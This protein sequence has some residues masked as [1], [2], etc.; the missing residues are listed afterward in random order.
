VNTT[1]TITLPGA[2]IG[3]RADGRPIYLAAGG[4]PDGDE[5]GAGG[6]AGTGGAAGQSGAGDANGGSGTD[7]KGQG[8]S[9]QHSDDKGGDPAATI[10]R[11][12]KDL[13]SARAEAGK[14][15]TTAKQQ[16]ADEAVK[17]VTDQIATA[18]GLKKDDKPDP[19]K[20]AEQ[21]TAAQRDA[22]ESKVELAVFRNASKHQG[23]ASALLDSRSFL[24]TLA[25]LDPAAK[26][27]DSKVADAIKTA[28]DDNPKLKTTGQA[29]GS[30]SV[31][32]AGGTGEKRDRT[33][34]PLTDAVAGHYGTA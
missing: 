5:T 34:R 23:D 7:D 29:P 26:D 15:R 17:Q 28:V 21:I 22:R 20:L 13:A 10:A 4:A 32:H 18:L 3:R 33:P 1:S 27:F 2:L 9:G 11:L 24:R 8:G 6:D 31:D 19:A 12:E 25:D 30:S 14:A 16:A